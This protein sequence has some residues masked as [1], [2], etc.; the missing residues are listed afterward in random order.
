MLWGI[1]IAC[2]QILNVIKPYIP[3]F[4]Y[5]KELNSKSLRIEILNIDW[6]ELWDK[7]YDEKMSERYYELKRQMIEIFNFSDE[8]IFNVDDKLK[9]KANKQIKIFIKS[10]YG[11]DIEI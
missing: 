9:L 7:I 6:E 3:Y 1:I 2:S 10:N 8:I 11:I 5:I 4:K